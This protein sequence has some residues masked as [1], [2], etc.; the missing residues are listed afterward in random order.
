MNI[1]FF[2]NT[3]N[4]H[5][6]NVSD[7]L[8]EITGGQYIYVETV[9]PRNENLYGGKKKVVRPYVFQAYESI[10]AKED[11]MR[12]ARETDV[13]LFGAE[14]FQYEVERMRS[15][16]KLAFEI[17]E[18]VLKRGWKNV[19]SPSLRTKLW[20]YHTRSWRKL[21]LY[22]LC[23][24]AYGAGDQYKLLTFRGKCYKWGYF[25][26]VEDLNIES[27]IA[28]RHNVEET[29]C[30]SPPEIT[31]LM[32]CARFLGWKHPELAIQL[33][34][35]LKE[36]GYT[37]VLDMYGEGELL[38]STKAL[39]NRLKV[40]EVVNFCGSVSNDA[41][42]EA[43]RQHDIFLFTSDRRE[44][45]GAVLNEA[46][47]NGCAVVASNEIGS[48]PFLIADG[49]NG[50]TF[51]SQNNKEFCEKVAYLI[52]NV[53]YRDEIAAKAYKTISETWSPRKAAENLLQLIDDINVGKDPS[54][55]EGPCS[56]A[57]PNTY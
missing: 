46:M 12:M 28:S 39:A 24:S 15:T 6:A 55:M 51:T 16:K 19:L 52:E 44:G 43:M 1:V 42:L 33:A 7:A 14:S 56:K 8:Y 53:Q 2:G 5:Q 49:K 22:K 10:K 3:L 23:S 18:R 40:G 13:A 50:C 25:T 38:E 34:A 29:S 4:R 37:F 32:W 11:A 27:L 17:S 21:P 48:V 47:S 41:I 26:Q 45:W 31:H 20:Y 9:P 57:M 36:K 54:I 35:D 30:V